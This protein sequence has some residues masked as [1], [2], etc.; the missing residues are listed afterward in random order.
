MKQSYQSYLYEERTLFE[1]VDSEGANVRIYLQEERL[2][3]SENISIHV[4]LSA[5]FHS[6]YTTLTLSNREFFNCTK[7]TDNL[8]S[9]GLNILKNKNTFQE[10]LLVL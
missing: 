3:L 6:I 9:N 4:P 1:I 8:M 2:T 7:L 5:V 10:E